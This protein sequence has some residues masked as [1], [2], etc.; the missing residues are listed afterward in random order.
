MEFFDSVLDLVGEGIDCVMDGVIAVDEFAEEYPVATSLVLNAATGGIAA[1]S[2]AGT[3]AAVLS[4][5]GALGGGVL[6]TGGGMALGTAVTAG[7]R[8]AVSG[9][10][11]G[12]IA[13]TMTSSRK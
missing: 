13:H 5:T 7:T 4:S 6:S 9:A 11:G 1:W 12:A 3:L 2:N 10:A 8:V